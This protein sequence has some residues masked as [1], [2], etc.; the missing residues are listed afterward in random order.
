MEKRTL[1]QK[2]RPAGLLVKEAKNYKSSIVLEN[3]DGK[4]A[5][6]TRLMAIMTLGIKYG[7]KIKITAEGEDEETAIEMIKKVFEENL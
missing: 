2:L 3:E 5:E 1:G 4:A 6:A 7:N